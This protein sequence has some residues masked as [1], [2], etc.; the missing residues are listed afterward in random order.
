MSSGLSVTL[1]HPGT[2][3][4]D[5]FERLGRSDLPPL[6]ILYL[7]A[8]LERAGHRVHVIDLNLPQP[9]GELASRIASK[10]PDVVGLGTLSPSHDATL[11]L[12]RRLRSLLPARTLL[13]AGGADATIRTDRYTTEDLFDAVLV[14]EAEQTLVALLE[15]WPDV[16][17]M[18][19]VIPRGER[20]AARAAPVVPDEAAL[21]AR[22]LVP[23]KRY[24]GG[25]AY[26]RGRH[27]TSI[28]THRGCPFH[29]SFCEKAVHEGPVR[30]RSAA[31]ILEEIR[32]IRRDH[33]IHDVRF[34]DDVLM[35]NRR[36][37]EEFLELVLSSGERFH[38]LTTGR[39]DLVDESLLR[40]MKRAGCYRIEF[41]VESGSDRLLQMVDKGLDTGVARRAIEATR[42]AGIE[43]IANFILGFPTETEAE[44]RRTIAFASE[45]A[46]D[47][48]IFFPFCPFEGAEICE[49]F[50]LAWDPAYPVF[51]APSPAYEVSNERLLAL[52]DEAY[53]RFYFRPRT[54][55]RRLVAIRSPWVLWDLGRMGAVHLGKRALER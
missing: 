22:H 7:A 37:F 48:A 52:V 29:C 44:M 19:G 27:A 54:V 10:R 53:S 15:A 46:P 21:P 32:C 23:L 6:G 14:G 4:A 51:R 16:P 3:P 36:V 9:R 1:I 35:A 47:Y 49:Q 38:W 43:S 50:D 26:K 20:E 34:I 31:S 18:A 33:D 24:R 12:A 11:A 55:A 17:A 39:V 41:G 42:R 28:F 13:V 25:P 2:P 8:A 45:L 40:A 5:A 30:F